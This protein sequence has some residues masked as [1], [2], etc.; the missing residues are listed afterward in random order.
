MQVEL[1]KD[2]ARQGAEFAS[3]LLDADAPIPGFLTSRTGTNDPRR[4]AVYRNNVT[5]SL[6][7]AMQSNFPS[8]VRLLGEEFFSAMA[9]VYIAAHPPRSR[10][11]FE[12]GEDFPAFLETFAPT[13]PYPYLPDVARIEQAWRQAFHE[14][15]APV[16]DAGSL[17]QISPDNLP[18]LRLHSHPSA[19]LIRSQWAAGTIFVANRTAAATAS[20]VP[21]AGEW[22]LVTRPKL[23]CEVRV[24]DF[25][26]GL[27]IQTLIAGE[28]LGDCV[29]QSMATGAPFDLAANISGLIAC[30]AF[31]GIKGD[32]P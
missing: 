31:A 24:L 2:W 10:L 14:T 18:A 4:Y 9:Q 30:G 11:M 22:V 5:V 25:A 6:V 19:R 8:I 17:A 3:A 21:D 23:D 15:D 12:Y 13:Q 28:T 16:L 7:R 1:H 32:Y 29:E 26:S 20:I 27:F